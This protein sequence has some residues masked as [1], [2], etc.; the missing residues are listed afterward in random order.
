MTLS[1]SH[2]HAP[3]PGRSRDGARAS[4]AGRCIVAAVVI[5]G[6]LMAT[7]SQPSWAATGSSTSS[8]PTSPTSSASLPTSP[9]SLPTSS[10]RSIPE[11]NSSDEGRASSVADAQTRSYREREARNPALADFRGG[12]GVGIYIGGSAGLLI[13]VLLLILVLR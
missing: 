3:K 13:V 7:G 12:E 4:S 8:P 1:N 10:P 5:I 6:V 9:T 11:T 2:D